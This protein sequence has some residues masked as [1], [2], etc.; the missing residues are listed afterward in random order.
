LGKNNAAVYPFLGADDLKEQTVCR[1]CPVQ[2]NLKTNLKLELDD[3]INTVMNF[4]RNNFFC[5]TII[6]KQFGPSALF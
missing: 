4:I 1:G 6:I 3:P 5:N 2:Q